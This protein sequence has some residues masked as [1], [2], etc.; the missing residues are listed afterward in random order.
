M[1]TTIKTPLCVPFVGAHHIIIIRMIKTLTGAIQLQDF[2]QCLVFLCVF[3]E[4]C[5]LFLPLLVAF[6]DFLRIGEL[7]VG[8]FPD[9]S[10]F[11]GSFIVPKKFKVDIL[12]VLPIYILWKEYKNTI[13]NDPHSP[14]QHK[15]PW[16]LSSISDV[17]VP[18]IWLSLAL[19]T[20]ECERHTR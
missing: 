13:S 8:L 14:Y 7:L 5:Q 1:S 2:L 20:F 18:K 19:V 4:C 17:R 16:R 11:I 6:C 3:L 12:L 15:T 9:D 10:E